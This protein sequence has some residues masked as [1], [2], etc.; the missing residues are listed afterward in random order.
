MVHELLSRV[1]PPRG[2]RGRRADAGFTLPE[3]I[4]IIV[5]VSI[6]ALVFSAM[7]IE[8]VRTYQFVDAEKG[9]LQ[10]AR[11]AEERIARELRRVRDNTSVTTAA[12]RTFT[13]VD[14]DNA[15]VSFSWSGV[16]GASLLYTKNG[17]SR[18]LAQGVDSLAFGY[19]KQ[20][21]TAA[22]PRVSPSVTDIWRVTVYLRLVKGSQSVETMGAALV[23]WL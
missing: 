11:Y 5:V 16:S 10:E 4:I 1:A 23:R 21:G 15:T 6:A 22:V 8:A 14:R 7:F 3:L 9:M 13:F 18:T 12:A 20:D 2:A 19:W 17:T